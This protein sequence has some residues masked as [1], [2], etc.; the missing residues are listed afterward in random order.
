MSYA[1]NKREISVKIRENSRQKKNNIYIYLYL[2][3]SRTYFVERS[4]QS[5]EEQ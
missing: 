1:K 5:I 4:T 2:F 3:L